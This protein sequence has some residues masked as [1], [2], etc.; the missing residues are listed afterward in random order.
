MDGEQEVPNSPSKPESWQGLNH[1]QERH[2]WLQAHTE[3]KW[4]GG[5]TDILSAREVMRGEGESPGDP[6]IVRIP[7]CLEHRGRT[8]DRRGR[9]RSSL[10][11]SIMGAKPGKAV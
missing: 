3:G 2:S 9:L 4:G 8:C 1:R 10:N 7:L 11:V 6:E 5:R